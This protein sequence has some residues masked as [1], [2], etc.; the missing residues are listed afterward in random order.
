MSDDDPMTRMLRA[1]G[2]VE[3]VS[4]A[5][6]LRRHRE[7]QARRGAVT[8]RDVSVK[9]APRPETVQVEAGPARLA[10]VID[11]LLGDGWRLAC[12]DVSVTAQSIP[13]ALRKLAA[14]WATSAPAAL[15]RGYEGKKKETP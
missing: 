1:T 7:D 10:I 4:P 13:A 12:G 8:P 15:L 2:H 14:E 5:E 6:G 11:D 3:K 9:R